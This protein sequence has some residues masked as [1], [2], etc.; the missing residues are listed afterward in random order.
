MQAVNTRPDPAIKALEA[1]VGMT[2]PTNA[3]LLN[4]TD[5]G[6]RDAS[7]GF[8]AWVVFSPSP[9]AMPIMQAPYVKGYLDMPLAN[10]VKLIE[11]MMPKHKILQPQAAYGSEW[12]T[13]GFQ[14]RAT[15]VRSASGDYLVIQQFRDK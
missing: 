1:K 4:A 14:F 11:G 2:I 6:G 15:L 8:Y 7:Y 9:I 10:S 5:G 12:K 3:V 13:N